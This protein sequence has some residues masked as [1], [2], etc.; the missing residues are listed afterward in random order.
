MN[1]WSIL[2]EGIRTVNR[3][4]SLVI[5]QTGLFLFAFILFILI[6]GLPLIMAFY[7]TGIEI[8]EFDIKRLLEMITDNRMLKGYLFYIALILL[9]FFIYIAIS[10]LLVVFNFSG[11]FG[12]LKRMI[13]D[14][15]NF[16]ISLFIKSARRYFRR[17]LKLS[18]IGA[19][20]MLLLFFLLGI[21][22]GI[23]KTMVAGD[24]FIKEFILNFI[25]LLISLLSFFFLIFF[26]ALFT[27]AGIKV[28]M[29]EK[30]IRGILKESFNLLIHQ[31]S[32]L[33]FYGILQIGFIILMIIAGIPSTL[34]KSFS[35]FLIHQFILS[36]LQIYFNTIIITAIMRFYSVITIAEQ[37]SGHF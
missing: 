32:A 25:R 33:I 30:S 24:S 19:S 4:F 21:V 23:S 3:N 35:G 17:F 34:V 29:E 11:V 22:S 20:M 16:S 6:V 7:R 13:I 8:S 31:P 2:R 26:M 12:S 27:Y 18:I 1:Y 37:N 14:S 15:E 28:V 9:S 5:I 10:W 36:I